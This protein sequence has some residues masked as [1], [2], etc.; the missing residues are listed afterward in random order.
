M[1]TGTY[2]YN[3]TIKRIVSVFGTLFNNIKIAKHSS[4]VTNNTV[5]VPISY[6]PRSKF[7]ARIRE[8]AN[9]DD[10]GVAIKLPRLSFEMTSI[11]YDSSVKLNKMN[12]LASGT[13]A[14]ART[15]TFQSVPYI[16]GM[17]LNVYAKNQDD[18]LQI[19]EQILPTFSPEYTVT[20]KEIDGPDSKTDVPFILNGV[21]FQ[22]E[23]E[24]DFS[25]NRRIII[26]TLDFSIKVRFAPGSG[27]ADIIKR[28]TAQIADMDVVK[29]NAA[30][31]QSPSNSPSIYQTVTASQDSPNAAIRTFGSFIDPDDT[32]NLTFSTDPTFVN[33]SLVIG[34][35]S[36][37]G[38]IITSTAGNAATVTELEGLFEVGEVIASAD[39]PSRTH[40]L[41]SITLS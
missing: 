4:D 32:Y 16:I 38:G 13:G 21:S 23:Y 25:N 6:G 37:V 30:G 8:E 31:N 29:I 36:L 17:Q 3:A 26:Y 11:E 27:T 12:K 22:D 1:L 20:I 34:R 7:L 35:T 39:S 18:A 40:T 5:H 10:P 24:G 2:F 9:F 41:S 15:T 19:V 28:V 14:I 33:N